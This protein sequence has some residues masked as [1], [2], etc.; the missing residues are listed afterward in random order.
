MSTATTPL[1]ARQQAVLELLVG[2]YIRTATPVASQQLVQLHLLSVSPATIRNDIAEMEE[3]GFIS[4]P[5]SS[6]GAVPNDRAYRFYVERVQR[7]TR[8]SKAVQDLAQ[9]TI[10][11]VEADVDGWARAAAA[12]LSQTVRNVAIATTPRVFQARMKQLQLVQ[13]QDRQALV[14]V[15]MQEARLRQHLLL[16]EELVPQEQLTGLANHLNTL[17]GGK[18]VVEI[19]QA[20]EPAPTPDHLASQMV[21]EALRLMAME[22]QAEYVRPYLEGL[23]HMLAQPEFL[24]GASAQRAVEALEDHQ[25]IS[26][27]LAPEGEASQISITIG[28]EHR[29]PELQSFSV[30]LAEYGVPGTVSGLVCAIGPTR[31]DYALSIASVRYLAQFLSNLH[32][33]LNESSS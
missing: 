26:Y 23:G 3:L 17:L 22:E 20:W 21:A 4:R 2:D 28:E 9:R 11:S 10:N 27:I 15:V 16:L 31:M 6:A 8:P 19:K 30:V 24:K 7:R 33:T 25:L 29:H 14:I 18:T 1:N 32:A 13:L 5:H 12:V